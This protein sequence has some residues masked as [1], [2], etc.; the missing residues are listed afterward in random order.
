MAAGVLLP[1]GAASA[2]IGFDSSASDRVRLWNASHYEIAFRKAD[3]RILTILDKTTGQ[4]VS[5]GNVHGPWVLRFSD[6]TWLDGQNFSPTNSSRRFTYAWNAATQTLTLNYSA[7]GTYA[8]NVA[9]AIK[10]TDGP[11][12]DQ[13]LTITNQSPHTIELLAF[14]VQLSFRR[15]QIS[16]VY[17]PY[18]EG[19][20]L[21][22]SFFD[23]Y[24]FNSGYPGQ[25]FAD[26]AF[27]ELTSGRFAVFGVRDLAEPFFPSALLILRDD[28]YAGG[29]AKY[30]HDH[31][32]AI[33]T[34]QQWTAPTSV[35]SIGSTLPEAMASYWTRNGH[36]AM[37]RLIDKL[38]DD[39]RNALAR[40]VL[41]KA[42]FLQNGWTFSAFNAFVPS[43]P[44]ENLLHLVSFWPRGF[45]ENYP[46]YLPPSPSLGSQ[47]LFANVVANARAAGHLVM[48]YTNPTW[49]D[50]ESP[51][52]LA[53][54]NGL[55]VRDRSGAPRYEFYGLRGG[56]VISP[57]APEAITR[58]EQTRDE[59][60]IT[61]SC[62][63]LFEDQVGARGPTYDGHPAAPDPMRYNQ[64]LIDVATA[65]AARL[66]AMTE[67]G[68]DRLGWA[69]TGFCNS[70][71]VGW[72]WWP[73]G[74]YVA[75]PLAPLWA[76]EHLY[77]VTHNLAGLTMSRDLPAMTYHVSMGYGLSY[78]LSGGDLAW[79]AVVD[80][81]QKLLVAPLSGERMVSFELLSPPGVTR[82]TFGDGTVITANLAAGGL[83]LANHVV[84]A[85]GFLAERDGLV[86]G[87]VFTSFNGQALAGSSP[88]YVL[89]RHAPYRIEL[90]Q[91]RGDDGPVAI[92]RPEAWENAEQVTA[93]HHTA[94]GQAIPAG[95]AAGPETIVIDYL[96]TVQGQPVDH[97]SIVYCRSQD[98][99]CDGTIGAADYALLADCLRGPGVVAARGSASSCQAHFDADGDGDVDLADVA[100]FIAEFDAG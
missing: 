63:F 38:G 28:S 62:D 80:R 96:A 46:D 61:I 30:H 90:H 83:P 97:V 53:L 86:L 32:T 88:H 100:V 19:M 22:P 2:Q 85:N 72:H 35:L 49:W 34:G 14:P 65:T 4:E 26:F 78:D 82:T 10:P 57:H 67:G 54:G 41:L 91:P 95:H 77:F 93:W 16:G 50:D 51:T 74:T 37:P 24:D 69:E 56:Y 29:V 92:A 5:P 31:E 68:F 12:V 47:A 15:S 8:C 94:G 76:H 13:T 43:L 84:A 71:R 89:L 27:T 23:G 87:G 45:D 17:V 42:D 79:L 75:Y 60:T 3:G 6:G 40:A 44:G 59:F 55:A 7:L 1:A 58:Q 39:G 18:I 52:L 21:L 9:I 20:K 33:T 36:D 98:A 25:L 11:E 73:A 70:H 99:D 81:V 48:P 64:G 66:P